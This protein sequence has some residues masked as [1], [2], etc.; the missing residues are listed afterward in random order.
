[1]TKYAGIGHE[2]VR[3]ALLISVAEQALEDYATNNDGELIIYTGFYRWS[4]DTYHTKP[5]P[6]PV[7]G[8]CGGNPVYGSNDEV[9][10]CHVCGQQGDTK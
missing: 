8:A 5:D 3:A 9:E 1:M 2:A 4:D 7:C 6:N 10:P